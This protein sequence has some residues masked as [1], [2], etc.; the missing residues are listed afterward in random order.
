MRRRTAQKKQLILLVGLVGLTAC[1]QPWELPRGAQ[2]AG[3]EGYDVMIPMRDGKRLHAEVWRPVGSSATGTP[4][5][6]L[7]QRSPYGFNFKSVG[8]SFQNEYRE[9]AAEKFILVLED[10]RGRFGSEGEF[11][12]LR[13]PAAKAGGVDESTDTYDTIAYLLAKLPNNNGK[14]GL[15][16]VS[17][18]GWTAAMATRHPHPALKAISVQA[19]PEDEYLGDDFHH[20]GALRL[21]YAWEYVVA[22]ESDAHHRTVFDFAQGDPY[23]WYLNQFHLADLDRR[24]LGKTLPSWQNFVRHPNY[25]GY[26]RSA[27]TSRL[28]PS[29]VA[30]P[31]LIVA[32][33][34][35]QE[36]LYGPLTLYWKQQVSDP[37]HLNHLVVG[38][39]NHGG[40]TRDS[41]QYGPYPLGS[42]T[43]AY[44]RGSLET[45][46]FRYWLKGQGELSVPGATVFETGSN[47]WRRYD[48]WP[49][50][51]GVE[52]RPLYF[53]ANGLL[54][55]QAP[56][57]GVDDS[58]SRYVS[59]PADPVPYRIGRLPPTMGRHSTWSV[60]LADD[61]APFS[62]RKDVLTWQTSPL[63]KAVTVRGQ[64]IAD[65]FAA[66][67][68]QDADWV[69]KLIDVYPSDTS[70]PEALRG[71]QLMIA[72]E[73]FRGRFRQSF[74][75]PAPIT[76]NEVDEYRIDLHS[77][78][79]VFEAGHRI[80]IQVQ[81]S[82]FPLIDRN[83]QTFMPSIFAAGPEAYRAQTHEIFHDIQHPS[84]LDVD[85]VTV[86]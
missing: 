81:S 80:A 58:P 60:W 53:H 7:L 31:N 39:W 15:F 70:T 73:V 55:F 9:L 78:S 77:A 71:R 47:E 61:Q 65:L 44:F 41:T 19:S 52:R 6:I 26:W 23:Q 85:V 51:E 20:N 35:D 63:Q 28:M 34:W 79:H 59:D 57:E 22:H 4:L 33:W 1:S 82:W 76:P 5:P 27:V 86:R 32:G 72:D 30:I 14:V 67:T 17:Y 29:P 12:M 49:P 16:G 21:S 50:R 2:I 8:A 40:W 38:P 68:G 10:V 54:D 42:D 3:Y 84:A 11:V 13:P 69:V 74:E 37:K 62:Q 66:T 36:D 43:G 24:S 45:P 18:L 56:R 25:D 48:Q 46:W 75:H 64:V 83:P